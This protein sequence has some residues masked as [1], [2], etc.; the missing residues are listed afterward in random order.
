MVEEALRRYKH[1]EKTNLCSQDFDTYAEFVQVFRCVDEHELNYLSWGL[2]TKILGFVG[3][4][5]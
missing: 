2:L 3:A 4:W 1:I 5:Y